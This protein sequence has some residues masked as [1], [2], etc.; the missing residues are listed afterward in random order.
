MDEF[1]LCQAE[2]SRDSGQN[3]KFFG[4]SIPKPIDTEKKNHKNK[5]KKCPKIFGVFCMVFKLI[6]SSI[7]R[8]IHEGMRHQVRNLRR[9][10]IM[11]ADETHHFSINKIQ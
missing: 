11:A 5:E 1:T 4:Q 2:R 9:L 10:L 3:I 8:N 6:V 7:E